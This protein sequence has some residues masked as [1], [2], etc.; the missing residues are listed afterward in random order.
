MIAFGDIFFSTLA[1]I[2]G[3]FCLGNGIDREK[4]CK[5]IEQTSKDVICHRIPPRIQP[6]TLIDHYDSHN[7]LGILKLFLCYSLLYE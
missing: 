5:I 4:R 2:N 6:E 7:F 3:Y 1:S